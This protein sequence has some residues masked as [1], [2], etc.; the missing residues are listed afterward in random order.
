MVGGVLHVAN[1]VA[2]IVIFAA[3]GPRHDPDFLFVDSTTSGWVDKPV[4]SWHLGAVALTWALTGMEPGHPLF[5]STC[6]IS[7]LTKHCAAK[8]LTVPST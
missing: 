6:V 3:M 2:F 7:V 1:W 5:I 8:A 4:V